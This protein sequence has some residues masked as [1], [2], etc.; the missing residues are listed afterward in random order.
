MEDRGERRRAAVRHRSRRGTHRARAPGDDS[1]H[2]VEHVVSVDEAQNWR[3]HVGGRGGE[4]PG[5]MCASVGVPNAFENPARRGP[6]FSDFFEID[7]PRTA[8]NMNARATGGQY[9]VTLRV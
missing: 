2:G 3:C 8:F 5:S 4:S 1:H 6:R 7:A 9:T